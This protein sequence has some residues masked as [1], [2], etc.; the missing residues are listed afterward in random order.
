[1]ESSVS[2]HKESMSVSKFAFFVIFMSVVLACLGF[3]W[4]K[5]TLDDLHQSILSQHRGL[6]H[7]SISKYLSLIDRSTDFDGS[8]SAPEI[9]NN[10][11]LFDVRESEEY[12]VGRIAGAIHLPP[13]MKAEDF[14]DRY[15]ALIQNKQVIFYCSV[16]RRSSDKLAEFNGL[17]QKHGAQ[18]AANL[19]GGIFSWV[20][21][22]LDVEGEYVHPYNEYWGRLINDSS[23]KSY[24]N[25]R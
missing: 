14:E 21:Q 20:N 22:G 10:V 13:N 24:L 23:K 15:A 19:E 9:V 8:N 6:A 2:V 16:G 4:K 1:M 12:D 5:P 11:V 18:S 17:L 3:L 25:Q 7:I